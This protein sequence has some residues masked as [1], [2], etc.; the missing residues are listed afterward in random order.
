VYITKYRINLGLP[1]S[2]A[3]IL[4][5]S[6]KD[7]IPGIFPCSEYIILSDAIL[8]ILVRLFWEAVL[9][10]RFGRPF[11]F[12]RGHFEHFSEAILGG[13]FGRPFWEAILVLAGLFLS[14][15]VRPFWE[16]VLVL[17]GPF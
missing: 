13:R 17:A 2:Y 5:Q 10:G 16:A 1:N 3:V 14:I 4:F 11:W 9:G 7:E 12:W 6:Y 15:L 8:S